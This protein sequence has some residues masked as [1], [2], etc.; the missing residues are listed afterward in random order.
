MYQ[1]FQYYLQ[2]LHET[3]QKQEQRIQA[4]EGTVAQLRI[5]LEEVKEKPKIN[6][7]KI[8]YKFDQLKVETL[9]GTL[10]IGLNPS[11]LQ[12]IDSMEINQAGAP[13]PGSFNDPKGQFRNTIELEEEVYN[14]LETELPTLV[15]NAEQRVN[16][17]LDEQYIDF[18][19]EDI[20]IQIPPRVQHHIRQTP[21]VGDEQERESWKQGIV[22]KLLKEMENGICT[23]INNLPNNMKGMKNE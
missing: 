4:L 11:D 17:K 18:I 3:I 21:F 5:E 22:N 1:E 23:F 15:T 6:V 16:Q 8:E 19:K 10:N 20:K 12:G 9:E 13:P 7:E 2:Q 14:I